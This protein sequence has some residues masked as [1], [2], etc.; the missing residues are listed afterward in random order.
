[1]ID[2]LAQFDIP[3]KITEFDFNSPDDSTHAQWLTNFYKVMYAHPIMEGVIAW[4]FWE[5]VHWLPKE[6]YLI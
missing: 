4:G 6:Q 5:E 2:Q 1:M 3:V